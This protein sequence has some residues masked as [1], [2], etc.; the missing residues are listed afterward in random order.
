M[1]TQAAIKASTSRLCSAG[2][3]SE[4]ARCLRVI[5]HGS[6]ATDVV[7]NDP[8]DVQHARH[9]DDHLEKIGECHRPHAAE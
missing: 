9:D 5:D 8:A 6:D 4:F 3:N 7:A 2:Q 1:V